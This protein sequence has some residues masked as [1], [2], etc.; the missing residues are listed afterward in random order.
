M[1]AVPTTAATGHV[2][3]LD[4]ASYTDA[5]I[6]QREL[7]EIFAKTWILIGHVNQLAEPGRIVTARVGD[8]SIVVTNDGA[9]AAPGGRNLKA[10]FN[11]CRHRGH[12]LV[13][14]Q[15]TTAQS[16][17]CP[18]HAW[19]YDLS[20]RLLHARGEKVGELCIPEVRIDTMAGFLFANLDA[21]AAPLAD[22][23]PG[24][25]AELL[26][27][28]PDAGDRHLVI[29]RTHHIAA[30]WKIA[31][32]N[33]NECYHCPN[34]HKTFSA[35]VVAPASYRVRPDGNVI[36]H[37]ADGP[38]QAKAAYAEATAHAEY[39][40]FF[41]WPV[42]S[43]QCYPGRV[44]NTF[45]WLPL[46]VDQTLLIREWWS[47]SPEPTP[48]IEAIADLDWATTVAED[49]DL[50]DSVQ[51]GVSSRG[52]RPGPLITAADGV[53]TIHSE[54]AVPHLQQLWRAGLGAR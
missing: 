46:G 9:G 15:T 51:R 45:R 26:A 53:A 40:S 32:E 23:A 30:N 11:V 7:N 31:V 27:L 5:T 21:N 47:A 36:R 18:Y 38:S 29:R 20:G 34:V 16:I 50:M 33:Y 1:T 3:G 37:S 44:L 19:T 4:A 54:D 41:T 43:I 14:E 22:Y 35:G 42:S 17:T 8:E 25:E 13:P 2:L 39:G 6:Y 48:E 12:E 24:V 10:F 52:Y 49:F 28:A